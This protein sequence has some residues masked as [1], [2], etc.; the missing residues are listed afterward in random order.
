MTT[1]INSDK[2]PSLPMAHTPAGQA[3]QAPADRRPQAE[4]EVKSG[5]SAQIAAA[6][7]ENID[8]ARANQ[9]LELT[10]GSLVQRPGGSIEN[11]DQAKAALNR[12]EALVKEN[13]DAALRAHAS[14]L[15]E[16][17]GA[18]LEVQPT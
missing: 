1:P 11:A 18:L 6:D 8:V 9:M 4:T 14:G 7:G 3:G 13:P 10:T 5:D 17:H 16:L 12:M 2:H 15:N